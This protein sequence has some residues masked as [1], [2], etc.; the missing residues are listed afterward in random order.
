MELSRVKRDREAQE[1]TIENLRREKDRLLGVAKKEGEAVKKEKNDLKKKHQQELEEAKN[2]LLQL[3]SQ[4]ARLKQ[5]I[6]GEERLIAKLRQEENKLG[7]DIA[8]QEKMRLNKEKMGAKLVQEKR[9][10]ETETKIIHE[11]QERLAREATSKLQRLLAQ[12]QHYFQT[13]QRKITQNQQKI[14][15]LEKKINHL[16]VEMG[17]A[18]DL[19]WQV[20]HQ[21]I[22]DGKKN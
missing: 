19:F 9:K 4:R 13:I 7:Q 14:N 5:K 6:E 17:K 12:K 18:L 20:V 10:L 3:R 21:D 2:K 11:S 8:T 1:K 22:K 15:Q 16:T